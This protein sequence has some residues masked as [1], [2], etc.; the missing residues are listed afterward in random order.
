MRTTTKPRPNTPHTASFLWQL[1]L[2][3]DELGAT[4][5]PRRRWD[6]MNSGNGMHSITKSEEML[7]TADTIMW[8]K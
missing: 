4:Y 1:A 6:R 8:L 2:V 3:V 7:K 5:L